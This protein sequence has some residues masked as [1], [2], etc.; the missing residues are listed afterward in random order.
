MWRVVCRKNRGPTCPYEIKYMGM[1]HQSPPGNSGWFQEHS[2]G[3]YFR[4]SSNITRAILHLMSA[5]E[6]TRRW[7]LP[8]DENFASQTDSRNGSVSSSME[9]ILLLTCVHTMDTGAYNIWQRV[10]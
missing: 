7:P 4:R 9:S 6:T 5:H 1:Y 2:N 10:E 3:K 8:S